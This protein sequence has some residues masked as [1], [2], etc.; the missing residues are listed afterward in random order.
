MSRTRTG[1]FPIGFRRGWSDWQKSD[2]AALAGWARENGFEVLD[3]ARITSDGVHTL[4]DAGVAL[5][6]A[7]LLD[8]G[9]VMSSD[10]GKRKDAIARNVEYVKSATSAG[11]KVF[12]TC[13]IPGDAT[14]K[15]GENYT[16]AVESFAPIFHAADEVGARIA[17]EG[18][19]GGPPHY[20]NLCCTPETCRS[21][22]KDVGGSSAGINFDPSHLIRLQVDHIRFLHE[23]APRVWHVHAKDTQ[24]FADALYEFGLQPA[25]FAKPRGFGENVWRYTI[26]GHGV[27]RWS[28]IF[29]ILEESQY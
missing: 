6:T 24:I 10:S 3:L 5:G 27:A 7:D 1:N 4:R 29:R 28:E 23:F 16:L 26:P 14:R 9:Q 20:P 12:F 21:F 17:I 18:W 19:P 13:I 25:T 22:F 11:A 2:L 8:F 15:R